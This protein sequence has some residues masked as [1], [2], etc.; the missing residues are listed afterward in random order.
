MI[1]TKISLILT[2]IIAILVDFTSSIVEMQWNLGIILHRGTDRYVLGYASAI[3][4]ID[5]YM[6]HV[7][8]CIVH[9]IHR[10]RIEYMKRV[11]G[12]VFDDL[13]DH[14]HEY[15]LLYMYAFTCISMLVVLFIYI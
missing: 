15:Y 5:R 11:R 10:G 3:M 8:Q 14:M 2:T 12:L 1:L 6:Y 9:S 7:Y 13:L 4:T